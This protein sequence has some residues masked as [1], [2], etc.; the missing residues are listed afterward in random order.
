MALKYWKELLTSDAWCWY[1]ALSYKAYLACAKCAADYYPSR[2]AE[3]PAHVREMRDLVGKTRYGDAYCS[4]TGTVA[5]EIN[6]LNDAT[7][8]IFEEDLKD[9]DVAFFAQ[10]NPCHSDGHGLLVFAPLNR[11]NV[12]NLVRRYLSC[13]SGGRKKTSETSAPAGR[14]RSVFFRDVT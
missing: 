14:P 7:V 9:P 4:R 13:L 6:Y 5:K 10:A 1:D 2:R 8:N 11:K 3:T 12:F